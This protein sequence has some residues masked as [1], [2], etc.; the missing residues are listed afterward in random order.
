MA[1]TCNVGV[2]ASAPLV[3]VCAAGE[4]QA[5]GLDAPC[6]C[7]VLQQS[8]PVAIFVATGELIHVDAIV[9]QSPEFVDIRVGGSSSRRTKV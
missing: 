8:E 9:K 4:Q 1:T 7:G 3:D 2:A 5:H 6:G